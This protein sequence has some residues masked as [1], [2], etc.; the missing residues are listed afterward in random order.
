MKKAVS[1]HDYIEY[2]DKTEGCM[3]VKV[4]HCTLK[5]S[6]TKEVLVVKDLIPTDESKA[7]VLG[8]HPSGNMY[9]SVVLSTLDLNT[10]N[11][12]KELE[13]TVSKK[14]LESVALMNSGNSV[15][16]T[17]QTRRAKAI[18]FAVRYIDEDTDEVWVEGV[19]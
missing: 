16:G 1:V 15:D 19:I 11:L 10:E 14:E 3:A 18:T 6:A 7:L 12:R 4:I 9:S 5:D 17:E 8:T 13:K 2:R